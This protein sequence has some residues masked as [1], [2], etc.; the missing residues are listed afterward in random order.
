M[1]TPWY[2][3]TLKA[4]QLNGKSERT[5][6]A[7]ARAV[8][9][10]IEFCG[11]EPNLISEKEIQDYFI[12]RKNV[13]KWA[14]QTLKISYS[15]VKFFYRNVLKQDMHTFT[16]L[17]AKNEKRLPSVLSRDEVFTIFSHVHTAHNRAFLV[18][19]YSCGLRVQEALHLQV[20]DIDWRTMNIHIHRGKGAKDRYVPIPT[21]TLLLLR[22]HWK[23]HRNPVFIFPAL[24]RGHN[25]AELSQT[26]MAISSVQGA[27]RDAK[28]A[29][30]INK[31]GV[32]L[33]TLRHSYATHLLEA[34]VNIRTI[35]QYLGHSQLETTMIYLHLT[36]KG[37]E[38]ACKIINSVMNGF[39]K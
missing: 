14:P 24:G 5:Q 22:K 32:S 23:T 9:M 25:D 20:S 21:E 2:D 28:A 3:E 10:L 34:G 30:G 6:E 15:G 13:S 35:Q 12:Y 31:R 4:L 1:K 16:Y 39:V 17:R 8:R 27:F 11:K 37:N 29:A 36:R 19:L 26:P 38:D 18:T 33:H 7:Y